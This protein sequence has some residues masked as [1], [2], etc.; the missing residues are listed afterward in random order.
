MDG[1]ANLTCES[2]SGQSYL[3]VRTGS[4]IELSSDRNIARGIRSGTLVIR[5]N[6]LMLAHVINFA[7]RSQA[8]RKTLLCG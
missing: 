7:R 4:C 8:M 3:V 2:L 6:V 5:R 1:R